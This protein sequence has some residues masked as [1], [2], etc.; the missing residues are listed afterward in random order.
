MGVNH[1]QLPINRPKAVVN[2]PTIRDG[3]YAD[4]SYAGSDP[5]Y[6]PN[7]YGKTKFF[8]RTEAVIKLPQVK[9]K[10]WD[11]SDD[12]NYSHVINNFY[13]YKFIDLILR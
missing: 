10:L 8:G 3:F 4:P 13:I 2:T 9:I 1:R 12:D 11:T 5:S 6:F 7:S